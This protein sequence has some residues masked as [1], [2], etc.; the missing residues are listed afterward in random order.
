M[1]CAG[2]VIS[3]ELQLPALDFFVLKKIV[4]GIPHMPTGENFIN[5]KRK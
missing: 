4:S 5:Q 3:K 2:S 1:L